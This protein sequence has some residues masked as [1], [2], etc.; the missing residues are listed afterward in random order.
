MN[1]NKHRQGYQGARGNQQS[2]GEKNPYQEYNC[3]GNLGLLYTRRY[4]SEVNTDVLDNKE[5]FIQIQGRKKTE[6]TDHQTLYYKSR[7][8]NII[9]QAK[10]FASFQSEIPNCDSFEL[11]TTYPGLITG[12][13]II[14]SAGHKGEAILGLMF[15][16]TTGLPY[17]PG[18][19]IKGV[20]RSAFPM[21]CTGN[22][23]DKPSHDVEKSRLEAAQNE[24][25]QYIKHILLD[26]KDTLT[27]IDIDDLELDIFGANGNSD[28]HK[29]GT[30]VF[31]DAFPV[32]AGSHGLLGLDFI[33]PHPNE[34]Q[35]PIPIQFMRI[36]PDVTFRFLFHLNDYKNKE[37]KVLMEKDV[38]LK[39][40]K[41]ILLDLGVGAKTN[42]GYGQ[43]K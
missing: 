1:N 35:N 10:R 6:K 8:N 2:Q 21:R 29:Q 40:F 20:L 4:Y 5:I 23:S 30:D 33:T 14:H 7:N 13:G 34:F 31:F 38:K 39:L 22:L 9:M 15:D 3:Q 32:K 41:K 24:R 42:V 43:L 16:H 11:T 36:E 18:P 19:S 17:L 25:R 12:T 26:I 28:T 27:D 37:G